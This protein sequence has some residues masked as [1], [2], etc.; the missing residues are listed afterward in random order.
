MRNFKSKILLFGEHTVLYG[1][2][3]LLVPF[4]GFS[5]KLDFISPNEGNDEKI[6]S[7]KIM[8]AFSESVVN[9]D[10]AHL[11]NRSQI[12]KE[13]SNGLYFNS[14]IPV[15]YGVGSSGALVAA[16]YNEFVNENNGK[17]IDELRR[18]LAGLESY[19]H[20]SSSGFD[21]LV[22]YLDK[23]LHKRNNIVKQVDIDLSPLNAFII[24]TDIS[25][26]TQI[27]VSKFKAK[28]EVSNFKTIVIPDL[29]N[30]TNQCIKAILDK[31]F[32]DLLTNLRELSALQFRHLQ[33]FI[34]VDYRFLWKKGLNTN[35]F[36]LKLCGA[37]GGGYLLGFAKNVSS[38]SEIK[39][40]IRL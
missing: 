38:L 29:V 31:D 19:F 26:S 9:S 25:R 30:S 32:E 20:G 33:E 39:N 11:F 18:V 16:F 24:D 28:A 2:D 3:A 34:P 1:S 7:H 35:D 6:V 27:L 17:S 13:L 5:G 37:G 12:A 4:S 21:P 22:C 10:F 8:V 40:A 14:N 23:P 15:G 36:Y